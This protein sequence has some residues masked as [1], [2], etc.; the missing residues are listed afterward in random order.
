MLNLKT[1]EDLRNSK[2]AKA[3]S[4]RLKSKLDFL[5]YLYEKEK[6]KGS[7][8]SL[9]DYSKYFKELQECSVAIDKSLRPETYS[10]LSDIVFISD[11]SKVMGA[12]SWDF[13]RIFI[14]LNK[15]SDSYTLSKIY[16]HEYGHH[17]YNTLI[18]DV[19]NAKKLKKFIYED[20]SILLSIIKKSSILPYKKKEYMLRESEIFARFFEQYFLKNLGIEAKHKSPYWYYPET[21]FNRFTNFFKTEIK[22]LKDWVFEN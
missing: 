20:N 19:E 9:I 16:F 8:E 4:N 22:L 10:D 6:E 2:V 5:S 21:D 7:M 3:K 13:K 18:S 1:I 17:V 15:I 11:D 14:N 12:Y